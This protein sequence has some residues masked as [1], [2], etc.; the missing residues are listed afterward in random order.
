MAK[1][2]YKL[3]GYSIPLKHQEYIKELE[4]EIMRG[5]EANKEL[6]VKI[7][8]LERV[9][10]VIQKENKHFAEHH[11][12]THIVELSRISGALLQTIGQKKR[13]LQSFEPERIKIA[14][15]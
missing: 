15:I 8:H 7:E 5:I 11:E 14:F 12:G 9:Y 3:L 10:Q 4:K 1:S 6:K 2:R 13:E